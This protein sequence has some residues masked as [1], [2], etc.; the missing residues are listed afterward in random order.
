M[1]HCRCNSSMP[2]KCLALYSLGG[3][4]LRLTSMITVSSCGVKLQEVHPGL[5]RTLN[6]SQLGCT[7]LGWFAG[8]DPVNE[9]TTHWTN[10]LMS[11]PK[12][13]LLL[14][15]WGKAECSQKRNKSLLQV[16]LEPF[17]Q[18]SSAIEWAR[19]SITAKL[20]S[21]PNMKILVLIC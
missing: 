20:A 4:P 14:N 1:R 16:G 17:D 7:F 6:I 12:V 10:S 2:G 19:T 18:R 5:E 21:Y 13:N 9:E 15:F 8:D 3:L 11:P